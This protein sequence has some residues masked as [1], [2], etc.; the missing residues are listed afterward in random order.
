M[1]QI[2]IFPLL[3]LA[4]ISLC[5]LYSSVLED[6]TIGNMDLEIISRLTDLIYFLN[7]KCVYVKRLLHNYQLIDNIELLVQQLFINFFLM[8]VLTRETDYII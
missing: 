8:L 4:G 2:H 7:I 1:Y 6:N 3:T 5:R